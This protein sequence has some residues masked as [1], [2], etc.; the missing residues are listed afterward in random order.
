MSISVFGALILAALTG[1]TT[2]VVRWR[3]SRR[4]AHRG[5]PRRV[6][7]LMLGFSGS[8]KTLMLAGMFSRFR[9][10]GASGITMYTDD[11]SERELEQIVGQIQDTESDFLPEAT[12]A[13]DPRTWSFGVR[14]DVAQ[15]RR[16]EAFTLNYLDYAGEYAAALVGE[17]GEMNEA[18]IAALKDTDILMGVLDGDDVRG[19]LLGQA[20]PQTLVKIERL[21]RLL[22]RTDQRCVHLVISKWDTLVDRDGRRLSLDEVVSRLEQ[23]SENFRDF[24][25]NPRFGALRIIPVSTF[26][27][28]FVKQNAEGR[29]VKQPGATW[30][31]LNVDFPFSCAVPDILTGDVA[32]MAAHRFGQD[33]RTTLTTENLAKVTLAVFD[34][35]G[36]VLKASGHGLLV[37]VPIHAIVE[38]IR[39]SLPRWLSRTHAEPKFDDDAALARVLEHCYTRTAAFDEQWYVHPPV[40]RWYG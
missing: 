17:K 10:G 11:A 7:V 38:H 13:G 5:E 1:L 28:G 14:V 12:P 19:V 30:N 22:V 36:L 37:A 20:R 2:G 3:R 15:G 32:L 27:H 6:D 25:R 8:G 16:A 24:R 31:P 33:N 26:G 9:F 40:R 18:F 4:S 23:A 21:L 34:L 29:L 35:A 39:E